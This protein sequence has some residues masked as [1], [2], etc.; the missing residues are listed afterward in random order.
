M[1]E[2][3]APLLSHAQTGSSST[4]LPN[5][6]SEEVRGKPHVNPRLNLLSGKRAPSQ[7][8]ESVRLRT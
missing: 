3:D 1:C 8:A 6:A 4:P 5:A 7:S 2:A